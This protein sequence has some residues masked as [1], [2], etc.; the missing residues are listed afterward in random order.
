[1]DDEDSF[2][3]AAFF[4]WLTLEASPVL[5]QAPVEIPSDLERFLEGLLA[6]CLRDWELTTLRGCCDD[7]Q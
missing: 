1:M 3:S 7:A 6:F 2:R 5:L 4:V